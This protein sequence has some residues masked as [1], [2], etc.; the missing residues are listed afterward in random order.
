VE[1]IVRAAQA[2]PEQRARIYAARDRLL[3]TLAAS[4]PQRSMRKELAAAFAADQLDTGRIQQL[5]R[6]QQTRQQA[7]TT[8]WVQALR[9]IHAT[10]TP[11]QR[12][13]VAQHMTARGFR[14][15]R[16]G[17]GRFGGGFGAQGPGP[18]APEAAPQIAPDA[19]EPPA[20]Q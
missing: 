3:Q 11:A 14:K 2:T 16:F 13:A 18:A 10:L 12:Q 17:R 1:G 5:M 19:A 9:E 15:G 7:V 20:A 4:R 8:A 6:D